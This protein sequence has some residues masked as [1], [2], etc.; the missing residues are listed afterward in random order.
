MMKHVHVDRNINI[1]TDEE[2]MKALARENDRA[3]VTKG[4]GVIRVPLERWD[5]AQAAERKH[6]MVLGQDVNNARNDEHFEA[7]GRYRALRGRAFESAIELGCGPFP[8]MRLIADV[9]H[10]RRCTLVDPLIE[11]YLQHPHCGYTRRSL[12]LQVARGTRFLIWLQTGL[13]RRFPKAHKILRNLHKIPVREILAVPIERMPA[14]PEHDLVVLINVLEHCYD[15]TAVLANV[16]SMMKKGAFLVFHEKCFEH[17][18]VAQ[19]VKW[20]YDALHPLKAD[21]RIINR[22]LD[23]HFRPAFRR[24][25]AH[26]PTWLNEEL[27]YDAVYY[28]GVKR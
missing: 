3:F 27:C 15:V 25:Y 21:R 7:F 14:K 19:A 23:E 6:W 9:C 17:E 22:F 13:A 24:I 2:A 28:I 16:I 8:N 4:S 5:A 26:Q 18:S 11:S 10:V 20:H 1:C 12:F